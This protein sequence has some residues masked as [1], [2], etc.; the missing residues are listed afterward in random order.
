MEF[1]RWHASHFAW[2][3]GAT[4]LVNVGTSSSAANAAPGTSTAVAAT[5]ASTPR[6][7]VSM[8]Y[9]LSS[10]LRDRRSTRR[11]PNDSL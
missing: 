10:S 4:S 11:L 7:L 9:V 3:I 8:E 2:K 1:A 6:I 5:T